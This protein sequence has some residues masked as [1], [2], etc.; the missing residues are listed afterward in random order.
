MRIVFMGTPEFAVESL[1]VLIQHQYQ[2]VGVVTAPDKPAPDKPAAA[3]AKP[4]FTRPVPSSCDQ[5][6]CTL[7]WPITGADIRALR[8][9]RDLVL[10][11]KVVPAD[12]TGPW[13]L[14]PAPRLPIQAIITT[15]GF[16]E[17]L[18]AALK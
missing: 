7:L 8:S 12:K 4:K 16:E 11:F 6:H 9:G 18:Q 17:A 3:A 1:K 5:Q 13:I 14:A 15:T 10:S 2:V